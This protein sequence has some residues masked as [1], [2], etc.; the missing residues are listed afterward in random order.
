MEAKCN[1]CGMFNYTNARYCSG[2]GYEINKPV[3]PILD[4]S[5]LKQEYL[6]SKRRSK[7]KNVIAGFIGIFF[8]GLVAIGLYIFSAGKG[9]EQKF[10]EYSANQ[11]DKTCPVM[12]TP[13]VR[14]EGVEV[15]PEKVIHYRYTLINV[16]KEEVNVD[17]LA[18]KAAPEIVANV[19]S[20][21]DLK[22]YRNLGAT[23]SY[24]Y[25]DRLGIFIW[26]LDVT[27]EMYK[28]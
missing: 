13:D 2:C 26:R 8:F 24:T 18:M 7:R 21:P 12:I 3:K 17:T 27:P 14:L 4:I 9:Y 6:V 16:L 20:A 1:N 11:Y 5:E 19:K 25:N 28:Q 10:L 15:L 22:L 23:F